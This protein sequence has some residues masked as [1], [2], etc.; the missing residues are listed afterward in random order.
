MMKKPQFELSAYA[1]LFRSLALLTKSGVTLAD[2]FLIIADEEED[3]AVSS[4]Y[5]QIAE[6][7]ESGEAFF[8]TLE[9]T[10]AFPAYA[11][12]LIDVAERVGKLEETL[13][14]LSRYYEERERMKN[15]IL[16]ALTY[17]AVILLMMFAVIVVLLSKVLPVFDEVYG[18]LGSSLTG[19]A[20]GLLAVGEF[21]SAAMP[22]I[23]AALG[24]AVIIG[25]AIALFPTLTEKLKR[26]SMRLFGDRGV[27]RKINNAH[28]AEALSLALSS[29]MPVEE[30]LLLAERL[31]CDTP[32][33]LARCRGC[34]KEIEEGAPL[35]ETL[36]KYSFLSR[37]SCRM[38]NLGI[39]SGNVDGV[40]EDIAR[41]MSDEA[42]EAIESA[43][44]RIEPALV[45]VT[46]FLV[47][48]I[49]IAVMLPLINIMKALG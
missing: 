2:G 16:H 6:E 39:R 25:A 10:G 20:G 21:L 3:E 13:F 11:T 43:T 24:F 27:A 44:S 19:F 7:L 49:L 38:L 40:M 47:G 45:L 48:A 41:R 14:A 33:A 26:L 32:G 29:G 1:A 35:P 31:L 23:G 18:S 8:S 4:L 22:Y 28:L 42:E 15:S 9:K 5:R 17:P 36:E 37:S 46:S 30:G 12:G 34:R